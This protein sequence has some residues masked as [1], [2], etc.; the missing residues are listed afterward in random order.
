MT[1]D[2]GRDGRTFTALREVKPMP[3]KAAKA[4]ES[5]RIDVDGDDPADPA[6]NAHRKEVMT[7]FRK[8]VAAFV[9]GDPDGEVP[10]DAETVAA[11]LYLAADN[12]LNAGLDREPMDKDAVGDAILRLIA[13]VR[14]GRFAL[15][16]ARTGKTGAETD[17]EG[18][19]N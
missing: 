9:C 10:V 13:G 18:W 2:N 7:A 4:T 12:F 11:A 3:E 17:G 15:I 8:E 16:D 6:F 1:L 19:V 14:M 5:K